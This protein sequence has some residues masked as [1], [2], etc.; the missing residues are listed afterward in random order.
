M[1]IHVGHVY[2]P[3]VDRWAIGVVM[4]EMMAGKRP[5]VNPDEVCCKRIQFPLN[6]SWNAV[7]TLQGVSIIFFTFI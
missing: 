3:E 6:L 1:Q 4:H 2:A 5:F 7:C